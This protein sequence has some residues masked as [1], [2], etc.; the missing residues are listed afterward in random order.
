M[1][2]SADASGLTVNIELKFNAR[3]LIGFGPRFNSK[4][5]TLEFSPGLEIQTALEK[6]FG[7][8]LSAPLRKAF[9]SSLEKTG[10]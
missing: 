9:V 4:T 6:T 2:V 10:K 8:M 1:C 5:V 7:K 3:D